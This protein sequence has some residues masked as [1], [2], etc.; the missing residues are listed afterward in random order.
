METI[1]FE[2]YEKGEF[3]SAWIGVDLD[4]TLAYYEEKDMRNF[5]IGEPI[6]KMLARVRKWQAQGMTVKLVTARAEFPDQV[7]LIKKWLKKHD[8]DMEITNK[9]D[10][11]MIQLWDDRAVQVIPN[12]GE[13]ADGK[14]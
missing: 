11:G 3:D 7:E 2:K 4:C 12:T 1:P 8:L 9:K 13:R 10:F 5:I 6:P 14:E